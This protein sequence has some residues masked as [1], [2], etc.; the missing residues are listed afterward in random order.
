MKLRDE[1]FYNTYGYG[2]IESNIDFPNLMTIVFGKSYRADNNSEDVC[3]A[4]F[5]IEDLKDWKKNYDSGI[6]N[7]FQYITNEIY[8]INDNDNDNDNNYND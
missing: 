5:F 3:D 2:T 6:R 7:D 8:H 1:I 4:A